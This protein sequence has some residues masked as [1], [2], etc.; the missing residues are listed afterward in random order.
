MS[1]PVETRLDVNAQALRHVV[2]QYRGSTKL[3]A[4]IS[5]LAALAQEIQDALLAIPPL[6]DVDVA[7]GVNLEVTGDLVGQG[8]QLVNGDLVADAT[9]R[10]LI[11]AR[12]GRNHSHATG[13]DIIA[14]LGIIFP[15]APVRI[16]DY[17][18]MAIAY[19]IG[20]VLTAD[21]IAAL[22]GDILPRPM[23]VRLNQSYYDPANYFGFADD[24]NAKF[25]ADDTIRGPGTLAEEF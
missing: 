9:Y 18:N 2:S 8:R 16:V 23:G 3:L 25:F 10:L 11:N 17:E 7:T 13:E 24:P 20:V 4:F 22:N 14:L 15:G 21:E 1:D 12:I 6:D 5:G 19:R